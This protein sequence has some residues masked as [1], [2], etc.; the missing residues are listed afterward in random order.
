MSEAAGDGCAPTLRRARPASR[1]SSSLPSSRPGRRRRRSSAGRRTAS[2]LGP[3]AELLV[4]AG[5]QAASYRM[6]AGSPPGSARRSGRPTPPSWPPPS[7]CSSPSASSLAMTSASSS[8]ACSTAGR[9]PRVV[10]DDDQHP[11]HDRPPRRHHRLRPRPATPRPH[12][13]PLR[14][15]PSPSASSS[16]RSSGSWPSAPGSGPPSTSRSGSS[17]IAALRFGLPRAPFIAGIGYSAG[18]RRHGRPGGRPVH[19]PGPGR[20][21]L[22]AGRALQGRAR[23]GAGRDLFRTAEAAHASIEPA[24]VDAAIDRR[25]RLAAQG[26]DAELRSDAAP[27]G[28][29]GVP[30]EGADAQVADRVGPRRRRRVRAAPRR[31]RGRRL[32]APSRTPGWPRSCAT[33]PSTTPPP[34]SRT[35][36]CS[37]TA[38]TRRSSRAGRNGRA[39]R[40]RRRRPRRLPQGQRQ[41]RPRRRRLAAARGRQ[42]HGARSSATATPSPGSPATP[43]CC[44]CRASAPPRPPACSP[45]SCW[46]PSAARSS[47]TARTSSCRPC[48]GLAFYPED[49]LEPG[50]LLRN[51]DS[52][53]HR[54][55]VHG[56]GTLPDL[57]PGHERA[58][59]P[60]A[61]PGERAA[62]GRAPRRAAGPLPAPGRPPHRPDR[63]RRGARAVGAPHPRPARPRWSSCRSPRSPASSSRSTP[64]CCARPAGRQPRGSQAGLPPVRVGVNL[65]ARHFQSPERFI[66][67]IRDA[68]ARLRPARR[69]S[70]SWRSPRVWRS[71]RTRAPWCSSASATWASASRSTTSAPATR[72]WAA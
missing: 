10:A 28:E 48:A 60:A 21:G 3:P 1:S 34:A 69:C 53:L 35:S 22:R 72:C 6:R 45:R 24:E 47:S 42:A 26:S 39:L 67:T 52:A 2:D 71:P 18:D 30:L 66:G 68:V 32:H 59:P 14:A 70:W 8:A 36:C 62:P 29:M 7:C 9:S 40:R 20:H 63:R 15:R 25:R 55:K 54:A 13:G 11:R 17:F 31:R 37:T 19:G 44:C 12:L 57:R 49:G 43:S 33:G 27:A 41:P 46:P 51:A 56:T 64:G 38:S 16:A 5:L 58:R 65:S 23:P 50:D 61:R 4:L